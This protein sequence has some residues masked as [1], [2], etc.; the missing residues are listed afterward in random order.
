M[1]SDRTTAS[2]NRPT[3]GR[4]WVRCDNGD[5]WEATDDDL[6]KF[7]LARRLD[8]YRRASALL[9]EGLR[10]EPGYDLTDEGES[11][12]NAVRYLIE[13]ALMYDHSPWANE[14]GEPWPDED[15]DGDEFRDRLRAAL[16]P[17]SVPEG[18]R[19]DG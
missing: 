13:C 10:L 2:F 18:D 16:L 4:L 15:G 1:A 17:P 5:E 8:L 14:N 11:G 3:E 6:A 7:G 12:A 19:H 9:V